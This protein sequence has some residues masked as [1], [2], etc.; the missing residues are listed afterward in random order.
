MDPVKARVVHSEEE[1]FKLHSSEEDTRGLVSVHSKTHLLCECPCGC[2]GCMNLP[3]HASGTEK[4]ATTS[5]E[6]SGDDVF[7]SL[8]PSI[9]DLSGCRFHGFLKVGLWTF[10]SDSGVKAS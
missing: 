6:R 2:K 10:C 5:W 7:V 3:I 4:P 8:D 1:F 9:R